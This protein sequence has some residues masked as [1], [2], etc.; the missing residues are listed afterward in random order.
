MLWWQHS[1]TQ[2]KRLPGDNNYKDQDWWHHRSDDTY[3]W[4]RPFSIQRENLIRKLC[5]I[6]IRISQFEFVPSLLRTQLYEKRI[7][8]SNF[9]PCLV[10]C[11][12]NMRRMKARQ[13]LFTLQPNSSHLEEWTDALY[14]IWQSNGSWWLHDKKKPAKQE[15]GKSGL[16]ESF[17]N[18]HILSK[19]KGKPNTTHIK[20]VI[21]I[22]VMEGLH[23]VSFELG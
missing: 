2:F 13:N 3:I 23:K 16:L 5:T 19:D 15:M 21:K 12:S 8:A 20:Y 18:F 4:V 22:P 9:E 14:F 1:K 11:I 10:P 6:W 7:T 17:Q